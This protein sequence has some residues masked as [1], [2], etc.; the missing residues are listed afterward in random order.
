MELVA[1][2]LLVS[3]VNVQFNTA[4]PGGKFATGGRNTRM[5]GSQ[6]GDIGSSCVTSLDCTAIMA[7]LSFSSDV[8]VSS[9]ASLPLCQSNE[10]CY[11]ADSTDLVQGSDV[12]NSV[13]AE[14]RSACG[15]VDIA[16]SE[17]DTVNSGGSH[18][19]IEKN[20]VVEKKKCLQQLLR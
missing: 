4:D 13:D 14:S 1:Q 18:S 6:E 16:V 9:S 3:S 12:E 5:D 11:R 7:G 8:V 15:D 19:S 20:G 2:V 17:S 10:I